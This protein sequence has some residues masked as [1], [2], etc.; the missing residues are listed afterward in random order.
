[1][2]TPDLIQPVEVNSTGFWHCGAMPKRR[3]RRP[4]YGGDPG[5]HQIKNESLRSGHSENKLGYAI[6]ADA[7]DIS[8][9]DFV[10]G[11]PR[12]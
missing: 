1:M 12:I 7:S 3:K 4:A 11:D 5:E 6:L 8:P 9:M 10:H 2:G